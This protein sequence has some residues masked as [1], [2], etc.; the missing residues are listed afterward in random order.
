MDQIIKISKKEA[1][2]E[3]EEAPGITSLVEMGYPIELALQ[4]YQN[5]G[6]DPI[7]MINYI[8]QI[9]D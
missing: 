2:P 8:N 5:V 3:Q 6:S 4:A 1:K 9:L 7:K